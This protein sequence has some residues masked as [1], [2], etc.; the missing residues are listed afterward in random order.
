MPAAGGRDVGVPGLALLRPAE[1]RTH[2][3]LHAR[4]AP[5]VKGFGGIASYSTGV[6]APSTPR[7]GS[8]LPPPV[9][10]HQGFGA[11]TVDSSTAVFV[12]SSS[13]VSAAEA[14]PESSL[15]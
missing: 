1:G 15:A 10:V 8:S 9:G 6:S 14:A 2:M 4:R 3:K 13:A 11:A 5:P 7:S 12:P